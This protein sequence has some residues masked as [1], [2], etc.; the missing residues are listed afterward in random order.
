MSK[1]AR[2]TEEAHALTHLRSGRNLA[3]DD[4]LR[5]KPR[6]SLR[7]GSRAALE[8]L[9]CLPFLVKL[10]RVLGITQKFQEC[11]FG[12]P[13]GAPRGIDL[14]EMSRRN[15]FRYCPMAVAN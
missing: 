7:P 13:A 12:G 1:A 5:D 11:E 4:W 9:Q 15:V 8:I 6:E 14:R 10:A 3:M 2:P